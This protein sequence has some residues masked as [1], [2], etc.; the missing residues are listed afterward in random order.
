MFRINSIALGDIEIKKKIG[1]IKSILSRT[2]VDI[3]SSS[4]S[5]P[6]SPL[7]KRKESIL[8]ADNI[9]QTVAS[10]Q[11]GYL[12]V[13]YSRNTIEPHNKFVYLSNDRRDLCW[14]SLD[15]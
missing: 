11:K 15:R 1:N 5:N 2:L 9:E 4:L 3:K 13:K 12:M 7:K 8:E 14:K 6:E 10:L